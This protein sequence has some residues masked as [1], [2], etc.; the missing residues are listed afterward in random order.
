MLQ[1]PKI[2]LPSP[3]CKPDCKSTIIELL[4][5]ISLI[6]CW[7]ALIESIE[8]V[9]PLKQQNTNHTPWYNVDIALN[10]LS[11]SIDPFSMFLLLL[12]SLYSILSYINLLKIKSTLFPPSVND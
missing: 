6:Y 3:F 9:Y 12:I 8:L 10:N 4:F 11:V 2:T 5:M 1:R 7:A